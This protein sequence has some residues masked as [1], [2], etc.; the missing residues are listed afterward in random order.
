[1]P[2]P[3]LSSARLS[4]IVCPPPSTVM[5]SPPLESAELRAIRLPWPAGAESETSIPSLPLALAWLS[6]TSLSLERS[7]SEM[8]V[9]SV[10]LARLD[11]IRLWLDSLRA[12]PELLERTSLPRTTVPLASSSS[13]A[14]SEAPR[15]S[16]SSTC[17]PSDSITATPEPSIRL[18][19]TTLLLDGSSSS[20]TTMPSLLSI[21]WLAVTVLLP[22]PCTNTPAP[23][24]RTIS[25]A[26]ISD[27]PACSRWIASPWLD[28]NELSRTTV[29][30]VLANSPRPMLLPETALSR[31]VFPAPF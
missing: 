13:I 22:P 1:M 21:S 2:Q 28:A 6:T 9:S 5:P 19:E 18:R 29:W 15:I 31:I 24:E 3:P 17:V 27:W 25:L 26:V 11:S 4:R 12:M 16:L 8:P 10:P 20:P 30:R 7:S 14:A 23:E